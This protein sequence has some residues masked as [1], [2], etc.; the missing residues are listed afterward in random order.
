MQATAVFPDLSVPDLASARSFYTEYLGL[1]VEAFNLG[2][3]ARLESPDGRARLQLVSRD[4]TAPENPVIS[5]AAGDG[6]EEAYVD[7][8]SR[9]LEIVHPLTVEPWGV[10]RFFVRAPDGNLINVVSHRDR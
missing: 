7:A 6:V 5:V 2:W 8:M 4:L 9:G 3:M 10:Q 1:E